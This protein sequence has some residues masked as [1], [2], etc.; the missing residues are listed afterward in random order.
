[1]SHDHAEI[2]LAAAAVDFELTPSERAR[3]D[4]A[5]AECAVCARAAAGYR[6]QAILLQALDRKSVV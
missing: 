3:L 1:M 4:K 5:I 6:R 2:E